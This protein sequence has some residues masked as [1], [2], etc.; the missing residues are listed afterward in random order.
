MSEAG[1]ILSRTGLGPSP[2]PRSG[3]SV[4]R[5]QSA[6]PGIAVAAGRTIEQNQAAS[7]EKHQVSGRNAA[8][9]LVGFGQGN[10]VAVLLV[11]VQLAHIQGKRQF[12]QKGFPSFR[13]FDIGLEHLAADGN[14]NRHGFFGLCC[15]RRIVIFGHFRPA[16]R[17]LGNRNRR[18]GGCQETDGD[19]QGK[20]LHGAHYFRYVR[21]NELILSKGIRFLGSPVPSGPV[22]PPSYRSQCVAPGTM[23][24][25][26]FSG[27]GL[28]FP[29]NG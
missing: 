19:S 21:K 20:E 17:S 24:S 5:L 6:N 14:R 13:V 15:P 12:G 27:T 23:Q 18:A 22:Q 29:T 2:F 28:G 16:F 11:A 10:P 8:A 25:S 7:A 4:G 26:L 1:T 3:E 9:I